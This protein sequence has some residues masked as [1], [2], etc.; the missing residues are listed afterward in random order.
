MEIFFSQNADRESNESEFDEFETRHILKSKRKRIGDELHFT[1]GRG[2]LFLGKIKTIKPRVICKSNWITNTPLPKNKIALA[3]GFIRPNRLDFLVE[4]ITEIGVNEII[5]FGS[6]NGNY[7]TENIA[8][9]IKI[10]RQAI[11]QSV[12]FHLPKFETVKNFDLLLEKCN[13]F[14]GR[15]ITEQ[16]AN[17]AIT[18]INVKDY[19]SSVYLI[20]PE[21]GL[22]SDE[23]KKAISNGFIEVNLGKFRLRSETAAIVFG[24]Y[25][26]VNIN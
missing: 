9:W 8:R 24:Y 22:S 12:R 4:K 14:K 18:E 11:K 20:G 10:S 15:F 25:L 2:D 3:V 13:T 16:N 1:N 17:T 21:G 19:N 5:L 6:K 26:R 7:S 23:I